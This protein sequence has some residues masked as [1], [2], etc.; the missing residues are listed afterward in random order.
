M[1]SVR[2][3]IFFSNSNFIYDIKIKWHIP[4]KVTIIHANIAKFMFLLEIT[5]S[6]LKWEIVSKA[7]AKKALETFVYS[8]QSL[9]RLS[10]FHIGFS[11]FLIFPLTSSLIGSFIPLLVL[12]LFHL[13]AFCP[14]FLFL[15][16]LCR[17]WK[18]AHRSVHDSSGFSL[19]SFFSIPRLPTQ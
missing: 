5:N 16:Y 8:F 2:R 13:S 19:F 11:N 3:V 1:L 10:L 12:S 7:V 6:F 14:L 17:W 9:L 15:I 4:D 18:L